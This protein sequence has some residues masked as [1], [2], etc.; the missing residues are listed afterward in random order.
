MPHPRFFR[1]NR[2]LKLSYS[3][4]YS[5]ASEDSPRID[6]IRIV[7]DSPFRRQTASGTQ[8]KGLPGYPMESG[9]LS[10]YGATE[11]TRSGPGVVSGRVPEADFG[12]L[13]PLKTAIMPKTPGRHRLFARIGAETGS[14]VLSIL[15]NV[16]D[17]KPGPRGPSSESWSLGSKTSI[18]PHSKGPPRPDR[19]RFWV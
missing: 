15:P 18:E 6:A 14:K 2:P 12:D 5:L 8:I 11:W 17:V 9:W 4:Q 3:R 1:Q 7:C 10:G 16:T 19:V 13:G